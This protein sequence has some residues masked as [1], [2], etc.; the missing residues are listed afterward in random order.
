MILAHDELIH[1]LETGVIENGQHS[2]VGG[3]SIDI[4]L[5]DTILIEAD[6]EHV[7]DYRERS[8]LKMREVKLTP[9]GYVMRPGEFILAHCVEYLRM[10]LHHTALLRTKSSMGRIGF[11]HM[12]A[13]VVDPGFHGQLTLEFKNQLQYQSFRIRPGDPVG[14]LVFFRHA[15]VELD[16]SYLAKGRYNGQRGVNQTR[17]N[18]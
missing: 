14:Q 3:A 12:D 1:L 8:P 9:D 5:G 11:E 18:P 6:I 16:N 15:T 17:P 2:A 7:A 10:P 4:H 13:G